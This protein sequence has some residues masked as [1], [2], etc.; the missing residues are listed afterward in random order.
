M[1]GLGMPELLIILA[2]VVLVSGATRLPQIG[3][4]VGKMIT[5]FRSSMKKAK[6]ENA[7]DA[8][9]EEKEKSLPDAK[10]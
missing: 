4:G 1:F 5:N 6:Q 10:A 2:V 3:D 9:E 7:E 8:G